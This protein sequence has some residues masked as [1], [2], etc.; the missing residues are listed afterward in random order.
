MCVLNFLL[1]ER[2]RNRDSDLNM[3]WK[4]A[5]IRVFAGVIYVQQAGATRLI[6]GRDCRHAADV[7][8]ERKEMWQ[9]EQVSASC[10]MRRN[11]EKSY[12]VQIEWK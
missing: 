7:R 2:Q 4:T 3:Q 8:V 6:C 5:G 1:Q 12:C 10:L 11:E 9:A